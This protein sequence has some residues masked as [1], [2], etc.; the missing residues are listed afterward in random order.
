MIGFIKRIILVLFFIVVIFANIILIH[1][2]FP[3][4]W[5][6]IGIDVGLI[7]AVFIMAIIMVCTSEPD[8]SSHFG[9]LD[10]GPKPK[11]KK[12][13]RGKKNASKR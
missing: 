5:I 2:D 12:K 13:K 6:P 1:T 7:V 9:S 4:F 10:F 8:P 11:D 3:W